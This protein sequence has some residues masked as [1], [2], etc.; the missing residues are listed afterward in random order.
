M[1]T[2]EAI[3]TLNQIG[4]NPIL[5]PGTEIKPLV[6]TER[7]G[8]VLTALGPI[9][10]FAINPATPPQ[11][12]ANQ[13]SVSLSGA[14]VGK[15]DAKAGVN[16]LDVVLKFFGAGS[17]GIDLGYKK[18][19]KIEFAF[20]NVKKDSVTPVEL[21]K[22]LK[23]LEPDLNNDFYDEIDEEGK[24]FVIFDVLKSN[25]I[26]V[27]AY[28]GENK[29]LDVNADAI[30]SVLGLEIEVKSDSKE[31][32]KIYY[33]GSDYLSFAF[34]AIPVWVEVV[35]S[36]P[37]FRIKSPSDAGEDLTIKSITPL[38]KKDKELLSFY[39]STVI[40]R[41]TVFNLKQKSR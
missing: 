36:T 11:I 15:I 6:L 23:K 9:S 39:F 24:S 25:T 28:D 29:K 14:K 26:S 38:D 40:E 37:Y 41:N 20:G 2:Q 22:Y 4:Y 21:S 18:A 33:Q 17:L 10:E 1:F 12:K 35:N 32:Q 34:K 7:E 27:I 19:E 8:D 5:S 31:T 13:P 30:K 16:F 3:E